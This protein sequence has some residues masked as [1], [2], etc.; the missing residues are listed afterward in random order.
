MT[1]RMLPVAIAFVFCLAGSTARAQQLTLV[2]VN[3]THSHLDATGPKDAQLN[4]TTGGMVKAASIIGQI[5]MT[6]PNTLLLHGGD[7]FHGSLAFQAT[8]GVPELQLMEALGFDAMAVGNHEFDLGPGYLAY[9]LSQA[10]AGGQALPLLSA[11]LDLASNPHGLANFIQPAILKQVGGITVGIF[12]M[13]V[14]T[15]PT[16]N[17][18]DVA[19]LGGNDPVVLMQ[20]AGYQMQSLRMQ[21]AQV[22][23]MLSHLGDMY[24]EA[25]AANV[26]GIDIIVG[27]HD[28]YVFNQPKQIPNPYGQ[29]VLVV[30][31]GAHYQYVGVM[32][33]TVGA[34]G[35]ALADYTLVPVDK[36]IPDAAPIRA[37]VDQVKALVVQQ[38]GDVYHTKLAQALIDIPMTYNKSFAARDTA[39]GN[40]ITD[41]LR[42]RTGTNIAITANGL[43]SEGISKGAIVG[44]DIF[45]PV[46]YGYD[47]A[48]GLGLKLATFKLT[49]VELAK[50]L[51]IGLYYLGINED[52]FLQ[53]SGMTFMY[54]SRLPAGQR[55]VLS[56][57]R[58]NGK[59]LDPATVYSVTVNEGI[60]ML[61]PT[62][63]V[64][65]S[66]LVL[67]P[68]LEYNV[69]KDYI[70]R[71]RYLAYTSQFR[72]TDKAALPVARDTETT[73]PRDAQEMT[74]ASG[75]SAA[76]G[77]TSPAA[78]LVLILGLGLVVRRMRRR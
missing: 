18:G 16:T 34:T 26:P 36:N 21:G 6:E 66:D 42:G 78:A 68:E 12:G 55:V 77:T 63:G 2:H 14:P 20:I 50:S 56:S 72:I 10:F 27:A 61:L 11:N 3:D 69:L 17:N 25:V 53:V 35:V 13:T 48:T 57:V 7:A 73:A 58:I 71:W 64:Q 51:E 54:D 1:G 24:D 37:A 44:D 5:K 65:F 19:I 38:F 29:P 30:Q 22:V 47:T 8:F 40:L 32:H 74:A 39:M 28:H 49:G 23:I 41:A 52:I 9:I 75:C 62:M 59:A 31:A 46:S 4:G 43:I 76:P 67:R 45:R 15:N 70:V 33:F 60:A